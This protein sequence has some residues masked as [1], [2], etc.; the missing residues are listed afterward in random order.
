MVRS[1]NGRSSPARSRPAATA[2]A[3]PADAPRAARRHHA[4]RLEILG[5]AARAFRRRGFA[6]TGMREIAAEADLSTANLYHYFRGKHELLYFCQAASLERLVAA[7]HAAQRSRRPAADR[8]RA[9]VAA[10]VRCVLGEMEGATAH[11]EVDDLPPDLRQRIVAGRDRYERGVRGLVAS[12]IAA[13][14]L[15]PCDPEL[16]TRAILGAVNWTARWY[17]PDGER[18]PQE[19]GDAFAD[20]LVR[21]LELAH[22]RGNGRRRA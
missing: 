4:R 10:H 19:V 9:V 17:R 15:A 2:A 16:V 22:R 12:G 21:G 8:L 18:S 5:A 1:S 11:L 13:G 14:D 3:P 6:A 20:Y 7:L